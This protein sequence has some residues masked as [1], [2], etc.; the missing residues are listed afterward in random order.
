MKISRHPHRTRI[1]LILSGIAFTL[2]AI[3]GVIT[4]YGQQE[5]E[6]KKLDRPLMMSMKLDSC[7]NVLHG[8][9]YADYEEIQEAAKSLRAISALDSWTKIDTPE[10]RKL[11]VDFRSAANAMGAMAEKQNL[12]GAALHFMQVQ[13]SCIECH[14]LIRDLNK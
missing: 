8:L 3:A 4:A 12:E 14:K 7:K 6:K 10:Y 13:M 9:A 5:S 2:L 11:S 1:A